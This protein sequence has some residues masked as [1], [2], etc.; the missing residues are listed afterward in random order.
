MEWLKRMFR[1]RE[2]E[3]GCAA[4]VPAAGSSYRMGGENKLLLSIDDMPVIVRT[5]QA[6]EAAQTV[7]EIILATRECDL[8]PISEL[9]KAYGFTKPIKLVIG[10]EERLH[11]VW[12]ACLEV[13][14]AFNLIAVHDGDRPLITPELFDRVVRRAVQCHAVVPA[15]PVKDTIKQGENGRVIATLPRSTL[16][17]VQTPQVFDAALLKAALKAAIDG[18]IPVSDDASCV[19]LLGKQVYMEEGDEENLKITT[20][21]DLQVARAI[22]ERRDEHGL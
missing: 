16:W 7:R 19:E 5:V 6:L 18:G 22:L 17:A 14:P 13:D 8:I 2:E 1:Q 20:T 15:V 12:N 10:G 9:I 21:I 3:I 11:S 4:V